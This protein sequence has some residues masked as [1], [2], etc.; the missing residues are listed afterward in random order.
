MRAWKP[1]VAW[2][3]GLVALCAAGPTPGGDLTGAVA[4]EGLGAEL[5][6]WIQV[7]ASSGSAP[8]ARI[9]TLSEPPDGS[10]RLFVND[11][12]GPLHAI[13]GAAVH[14][15]LDLATLRP[16]LKISPGLASGFVSLTFHPGFASN[17]HFYTVHTESVGA[18]PA[19]LWPSIATTI[20]QHSVLTEWTA[21]NPAA[22][23][24]SGTSRELLRIAAPH[25]FHNMGELA[26]DPT[27][28]PGDP[29]YGWLYI[30]NGDYGSVANG[31]PEQLQRV[32]TPLGALLRID[33]LGGDGSAYSYGIPSTN[34]FAGDMD[35]ATL[36][37]I[38]ATG[39]RNAH[40]ISWGSSAQP[41]P[42]V[43]DI[44]ESNVEEVNIL[45]GGA[46]YGWPQREGTLALD[47]TS[48]PSSVFALP[49]NDASFGYRYPVAQYDHDEGRAI[50]GGF[51]YRVDPA[52][53]LYDKFI[54]GDIATG[55]I[56]Y[57]DSAAM[58][59]ADDGDPATAAQVYELTL[60]VSGAPTTLL[61]VVRAE[62]SDPGLVRVDLRFASDLA[63]NLYVTTKQDGFIRR[64]L[65]E[66]SP[67][68]PSLARPAQVVLA[69]LL[70]GIASRLRR[71]RASLAR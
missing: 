46:N 59:A 2:C 67:T 48:D 43:S 65:P 18:T 49:G 6:D 56:L 14:S 55:R 33:P 27:P 70:L 11:L 60:S 57:A 51:V 36:D 35:P 32:D 7:P 34:P 47:V 52:S 20:A 28:M 9:N 50:A 40:R 3:C 15:Y 1:A 22:N 42:Y 41:G 37:E 45:V 61:D 66:T 21:S 63:G 62:L 44:G 17:G 26:F 69:A 54:F 38:Y 12:R 19:T 68:V 30:A 10:G 4:D 53:P 31:E 5:E 25:R 71:R 23:S 29:D 24:F 16:A 58:L 13:D 8:L 64:L 39:F